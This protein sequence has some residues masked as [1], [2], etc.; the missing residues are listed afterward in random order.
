MKKR[1][2]AMVLAAMMVVTLAACSQPAAET[3]PKEHEPI[4]ISMW[5]DTLVP[6]TDLLLSEDQWWLNEAIGRFKE[7]YPYVTV[8]ITL[9]SDIAESNNLFRSASL[10]GSAPDIIETWSGNWT[11]ELADYALPVYDMMSPEAR[12]RIGGWETVS[13]GFSTKNQK[14]GVPTAHQGFGCLY[15]NKDIIKAAGLDFEANPPKTTEE[16]AAACEAI[17]NAGY[18]PILSNEGSEHGVFYNV[19]LYWWLQQVGY[20]HF[21]KESDGTAKYSEDKALIDFMNFYASLY[22]KGYY[23]EDTLSSDDAQSRFMVGDG[24]MFAA[25][26]SRIPAL[27]E[28]M[29]DKLGVIKPTDMNTNGVITNKLIGG[30]GQ[31]MVVSKDTKYPDECIALIEHLTSPEEFEYYYKHDNSKYP[32]VSGVNAAALGDIDPVTEKLLGW[33]V[34]VTFWPD[35]CV[36]PDAMNELTTYLPD[37]MSGK[38]TPE[39]IALAMDKAVENK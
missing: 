3:A 35:N 33:A 29:G 23:N 7:K 9:E 11:T 5:I 39:E 28:E 12:D 15:Y 10:A 30:P 22:Q 20:E 32:N 19:A 18:V 13:V 4:T 1:I 31:A 27:Y 25:Y 37:L 34:D 16:F 14:V 21:N 6:K 17:K 36:Y 38:K 24:A 2:L 26:C 8:D